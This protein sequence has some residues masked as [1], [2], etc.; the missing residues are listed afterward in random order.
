IPMHVLATE[1]ATLEEADVAIDLGQSPAEIVVLSF[2]DSDL[3]ALAAAWQQD[4][5]VLP[6]LRLASLKRLGHP[7]S[8]ALYVESVVARAR[9]VIV[10]CLGGLDYWRYGFEHIADVA[11]DN[12]VLFAALPGDDRADPRLAAASTLA[13]EPLARLDR[14]FREGGGENLRQALRYVATLLGRDLAWTAPVPVGPI[15][16][17]GEAPD[18]RPVALVVFYRANLMAADIAPI[19]S[20]MEAL[21]RQGLAP[22]GVAVS[23]LKDAEIRPHLEE[24]IATHRPAIILNTTAFSA[25][26]GDDTTVLDAA[27]VPVLQA[28]LSGSVREAW[29][30]SARGLSPADLAMNVVLPELDGRLLTRA[31]SFKAE[32]PTDPRLEFATVRHESVPDRVDYVA[33]LA[34]AWAKLG[35]KRPAERRLALMLCDYPARGG[36]T[37]YAVGLDTT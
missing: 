16:V 24:L 15:T 33:R 7:M 30:D 31:I 27:D 29:K 9:I 2:S 14:F 22:L 5:D 1:R 11:R 23:S 19:N 20:L 12:G 8:V 10:R 25:L 3:S 32:A 26:R 21:D 18:G 37:G 35:R 34:A 17:L 36:R 13:A 4:A 6:T 28:V